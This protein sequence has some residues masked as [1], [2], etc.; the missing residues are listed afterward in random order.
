MDLESV[1]GF[2]W[3]A[4][5]QD[6]VRERHQ[7]EPSECETVFFS[8]PLILL[9]DER[10]SSAESRYFAFGKGYGD[11]LLLIVFCLRKNRIRVI[12]ARP[13]HKKERSFYEAQ[14]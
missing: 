6:K 3:D 1:E 13:M 11:R 14:A 5:N 10:H 4:G 8:E 9:D 2:D 7:V 12:S